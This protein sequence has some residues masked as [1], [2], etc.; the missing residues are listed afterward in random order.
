MANDSDMEVLRDL[1]NWTR[2][3]FYG[4]VK[5]MLTDVLNSENKRLAYQLTDGTKSRD[6]LKAAAGMGSDS[7]TAL[8][9]QCVA[10]G[11]MEITPDNKKRRLF[12]LNNFGLMP[13]LEVAKRQTAGGGKE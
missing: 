7:I 13:Q 6:A 11:L 12:D 8:H 3:G 9:E 2:V 10:L 4:A 5:N 1:L